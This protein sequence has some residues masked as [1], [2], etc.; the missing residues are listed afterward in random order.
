MEQKISNPKLEQ[1]FRHWTTE[2]TTY[3]HSGMVCIP[4]LMRQS[5]WKLKSYFQIPDLRLSIFVPTVQLGFVHWIQ[6]SLIFRKR[7]IGSPCRLDFGACPLVFCSEAPGG[8]HDLNLLLLKNPLAA[9]GETVRL[10]GQTQSQAPKKGVKFNSSLS[11]KES[12]LKR[13]KERT[14]QVLCGT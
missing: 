3:C 6:P 14:A 2:E 10:W 11:A 4:F 8:G 13:S 9:C 7:I 5:D 1:F 12:D